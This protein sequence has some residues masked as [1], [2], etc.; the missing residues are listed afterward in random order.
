MTKIEIVPINADMIREF[1]GEGQSPTIRGIAAIQEGHVIAVAGIFRM[2]FGWMLFSDMKPE[3]LQDKRAIVRSVREL[4]K[5]IETVLLPVYA[6]VDENAEGA[7]T[8]I[9]HVGVKK[10]LH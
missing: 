3:F 10:W 1:Y 8:L 6:K 7:D 9:E 2:E 5:L 4:R